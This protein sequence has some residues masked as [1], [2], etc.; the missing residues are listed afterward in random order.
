MAIL[1]HLILFLIIAVNVNLTIPV[2]L[3][4]RF[5]SKGGRI[6]SAM[7][8]SLIC[9]LPII[10]TLLVTYMLS[11]LAF[12]I[13]TLAFFRDRGSKSIA[14]T[15]LFYSIISSC[16]VFGIKWFEAM[17]MQTMPLILEAAIAIL[18]VAIY[19]IYFIILRQYVGKFADKS[20]LSSFTSEV[21]G[22][23]AFIAFCPALL[24]FTLIAFPL[25]NMVLFIS[26]IFFAVAAATAMFPL[27]YHIGRS[28]KL[29]DENSRLRAS[30]DYY[31]EVEA[32][33]LQFRKF[34][35]D[36]MNQ[37]TVI[38]TYLDLGENDKAISY[39]KQ[40][41][42]DFAS[43]T[44]TFTKNT[45]LNAILNSKYQMAKIDGI[46][47][48]IAADVGELDLDETD[49]CTMVANALDNAIEADPPDGKIDVMLSDKDGRLLFTCTNSYAGDVRIAD[50][51]SFI[52]HKDDSR[53][54]GLGIRNI[55]EAVA[56]MGGTVDISARDGIFTVRAEIKLD[57]EKHDTVPKLRKTT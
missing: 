17:A 1:L 51:G 7:V 37:F 25:Q 36:L 38:A 11:F 52:T 54:H 20:I 9:M 47:I 6:C 33:Q 15:M 16:S 57:G 46:R 41:G 29:A 34:K 42:A 10:P 18:L 19:A 4:P 22:Y 28:M 45:L 48:D 49:V 56:R 3:E 21:W 5:P 27:L 39:F 53:N 26:I 13:Y 30:A 50:D 14:I 31:Q 43:L 12:F 40:L 32:Q 2:M 8:L 55:R 23:C 44:R 24:I 35:H